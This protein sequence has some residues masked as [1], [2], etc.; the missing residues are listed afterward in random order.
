[1]SEKKARNSS[2]KKAFAA[3]E[4]FAFG[5]GFDIFD[6]ATIEDVGIELSAELYHINT[7]TGAILTQQA[8][9]ITMGPRFV[10]TCLRAWGGRAGQTRTWEAG[11]R[12]MDIVS[13][14]DSIDPANDVVSDFTPVARVQSAEDMW[15][16]W[17]TKNPL[18]PPR[19]PAV[20]DNGGSIEIRGDIWLSVAFGDETPITLD[21]CFAYGPQ[22]LLN[23][24]NRD[25]TNE[26]ILFYITD[27]DSFPIQRATVTP[28]QDAH[29]IY[30]EMKAVI[31][32]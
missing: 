24:G 15:D 31:T 27:L 5:S 17:I 25:E 1:M 32:A 14:I 8:A 19:G 23:A 21:G 28:L 16:G 22:I 13:Y 2:E 12:R 18:G 11:D 20:V 4:K 9:A 10:E 6:F 3:S 26:W 7:T 30:I 29:S